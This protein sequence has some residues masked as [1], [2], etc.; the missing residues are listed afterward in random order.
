MNFKKIP[1]MKW[2]TGKSSLI[3][4]FRD[5][6]AD[7]VWLEQGL[8]GP[9]IRLMERFLRDEQLPELL[10]Q[11]FRAAEKTPARVLVCLP[12]ASVNVVRLPTLS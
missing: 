4:I 7:A 1:E 9:A 10:A 2:M 5:N 8:L 12:R 11:R 3:L 6:T